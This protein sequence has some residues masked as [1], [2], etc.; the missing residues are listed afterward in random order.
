MRHQI[1]IALIML[2]LFSVLA[3]VVYPLLVTGIAQ[4]VFNNM[5]NGSLIVKSG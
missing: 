3:G 2:V 5:A 1:K 4:L